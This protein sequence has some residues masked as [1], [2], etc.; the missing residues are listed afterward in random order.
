MEDIVLLENL[1]VEVSLR[2]F[3]KHEA[4]N[5]TKWLASGENLQDLSD[6][7]DLDLSLMGT[8]VRSGSFRTDILA[9]DDISGNTVVI[10]NQ[11]MGSNHDHLGKCLTYLS[12]HEAKYCIWICKEVRP[13]HKAAID[14]LN[15]VTPPDYRFYAIELHAYFVG[16]EKLKAYQYEIVAQ[17]DYL[18]K[19]KAETKNNAQIMT[20]NNFWESVKATLPEKLQKRSHI[21][22][23]GKRYMDISFDNQ[24]FWL[25]IAF[26]S[27]KKD[28]QVKVSIITKES[29]TGKEIKDF[30]E[31]KGLQKQ[32]EI[33]EYSGKKNKNW[34]AFTVSTTYKD[35]PVEC[36][37]WMKDKASNLYNEF[38]KF[39]LI[40]Q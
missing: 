20:L 1:L 13:E 29:D 18:D 9:K 7:L 21:M 25:C 35:N 2:D 23:S 37:D 36:I 17:P 26:T 5:F 38:E 3:W 31:S 10:E 4:S 11:L 40:K 14:F 16:K 34:C 22:Y 27:P 24:S 19:Y 30:I 28:K 33:K 39:K 32:H 8:E 6:L 12:H 15:R